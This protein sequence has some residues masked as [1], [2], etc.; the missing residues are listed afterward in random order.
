MRG[1]VAAYVS[2]LLLVAAGAESGVKR[3]RSGFRDD[4][5]VVLK[6]T[7]AGASTTLRAAPG[8][9]AA[10][11]HASR[12]GLT[13]RRVFGHALRGYAVRMSRAQAEA[14]ARDPQVAW[15]EENGPVRGTAV[16]KN[17]PW[18]LDRVDQRH[19]GLD[20]AYSYRGDGSGVHAY[21]IDSGLAADNADFSGRVE[22]GV[23]F[24]GDGWGTSDCAGTARTPRAS[25]A[26]RSTA[27]RKA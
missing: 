3:H 25:W 22:S 20:D 18:G 23:D 27:S 26:A 12:H 24:V 14:L 13:P 6:S 5:L 10:A 17:V 16:Q 9:T 19:L 2:V 15:V 8:H 21:V 11:L 7:A 4:Y 1:V